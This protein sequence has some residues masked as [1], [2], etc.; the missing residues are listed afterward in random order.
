MKKQ[1]NDIVKVK[2]VYTNSDGGSKQGVKRG[3]RV[4]TKHPLSLGG[5]S[6][7]ESFQYPRPLEVGVVIF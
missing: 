4:G 1:V 5:E 2:I 7:G 3:G 6:M